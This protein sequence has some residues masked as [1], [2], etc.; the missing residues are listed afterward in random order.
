MIDSSCV[1]CSSCVQV[2]PTA[3][4]LPK[5][6]LGQGRDWEFSASA[7]SAATAASAAAS[8]SCSR[9]SEIVYAQGY[10]DAPVNGEFL[11][12]KGR[13][14]WDF[15]DSPDRLT[16]AAGA[17]R[18]GLRAGPDRRTVGAARH[19]P[20][21]GAQGRRLLRAGV[22]GD[23]HRHRRRASWPRVITRARRRRRGRAL[24]GP[25]HQRGELSL[26]EVHARRHRH[27]QRGPLRPALPRQHG[28]RPG[29]GL[30]QRRHD[31]LHQ[32]ASATP[33]ASSSPAPTPPSPT[34]SS[35]TRWC[36][37]SRRAHRS[38]S[39]TRGACP[40]STTPRLWLQPTPG[41]DIYIFL[42]M[43]HVIVREG[44]ADQA[45]IDARTEGFAEFAAALRGVHAR[46]RSAA[47]RRAGRKDRAGGS[48]L[49]AGAESEQSTGRR[50]SIFDAN[51]SRQ[52]RH[53]AR[54]LLHP[55]RHGHHPAHQRH[56][57]GAEPGQPGHAQRAD[58]QAVR[59]AS[60]RCAASPT[61]RARAT[62]A[63]CPTCCPA[64]SR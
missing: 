17:P 35:A 33:T 15:I 36:A 16:A 26:P 8:S 53:R 18:P 5:P 49:R 19:Q 1:F 47:L 41:T 23:G 34:R 20:A 30:W 27:Q 37:R 10:A 40:W 42:A 32:R 25:L 9:T 12:V 50:R 63:R 62:W 64:T 4:L 55:L 43:A 56:R 13:S 28:H 2:C 57:P 7:R 58:R 61:C 31:Q 48:P 21:Q 11:C 44:W 29:H 52:C 39:S 60:I 38:S 51:G 59:R 22:V 14:G 24:L 6:R 3:A 54:R 45:F 46:G